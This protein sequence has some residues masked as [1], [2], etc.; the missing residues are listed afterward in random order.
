MTWM[1]ES[2]ARPEVVVITG[3]AAGVGRA[4]AQAFARRGA[5]VGLIARGGPGMD[6]LEGARRDVEALG[7]RALVL[8]TDVADAGAVLAAAERVEQELGPIDV[9]V[10]VAMVSVFSPFKEMTPEEFKRVTEVTYL[11]QVYGVMAALTY[12][13]P[14]NRGS[15][16]LVGSALAYRSIPLQSAYCGAKSGTRGFIDSVRSEL[17]HDQSKI[18]IC[19]VQM[20]ALNTPQFSWVK[21]RLP[22]NPQPV[23]PI[24]QPEIAAEA[25]YFAAHHN[26]REMRVGFSTLKAMLG[27]M[28]APGLLDSYLART[29]YQAQQTD[30][31]VAPDRPDNLWEA[32]PGD[33]GAHGAFDDRSQSTSPELWLSM[34][35]RELAVVGAGIGAVAGALL[36]RKGR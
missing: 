15:I 22:N 7:G 6:G 21:S 35:A 11:G 5:H 9:W 3:A 2:P 30:Q 31:P 17:I 12:M 10:N 32:L 13:I 4:A 27:N 16:V 34:H 18:Q 20:P 24:Y 36:V 26:R 28:V 14:R 19:M 23:P 29:G 1:N 25:I 8:P 33:H